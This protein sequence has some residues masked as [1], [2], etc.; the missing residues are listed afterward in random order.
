MTSCTF[1][2]AIQPQL[3]IPVHTVPSKTTSFLYLSFFKLHVSN[4]VDRRQAFY[5]NPQNQNEMLL[6]VSSFKHYKINILLQ[7]ICHTDDTDN[8]SHTLYHS[9]IIMIIIIIITVRTSVLKNNKK[10]LHDYI[11]ILTV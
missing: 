1:C 7:N 2:D 9:I 5:I 3:D 6:F 11:F 10:H 4:D 8:I